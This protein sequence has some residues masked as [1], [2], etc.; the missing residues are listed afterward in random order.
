MKIPEIEQ[1]KHKYSTYKMRPLVVKAFRWQGWKLK[2]FDPFNIVTRLPALRAFRI[3]MMLGNFPGT[4]R[5][6][7]KKL[8]WV[9]GKLVLP[10]Q[11]IVYHGDNPDYTGRYEVMDVEEF[12]LR[13]QMCEFVS[14]QS[15][16][17]MMPGLNHDSE[18]EL[19]KQLQERTV[20]ATQDAAGFVCPTCNRDCDPDTSDWQHIEGAWQ[21]YHGYLSG[22]ITA[23]P[24]PAKKKSRNRA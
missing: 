10:G 6:P 1:I 5:L 18:G 14:Q 24:K 7:P 20:A 23:I 15:Y 21:H 9:N 8:G 3:G 13:Y 2:N 17:W 22:W 11:Y 16:N 19:V 12:D 4:D